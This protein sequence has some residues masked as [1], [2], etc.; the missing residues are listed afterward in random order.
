T[1]GPLHARMASFARIIG[2]SVLIASVVTFVSGIAL[3][4]SASAMFHTAVAMA[5]SAVPEGLPVAVT[6]TL[7]I[8]VSRM[9]RRNAVLRRLASME[10]LGSTTVVGSDKT[11]TLTENRMAVQAIWAGGRVVDATGDLCGPL[12]E[13]DALRWTLHTGV[14]TNEA[15]LVHTSD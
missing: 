11:G 8:G 10:T 6:V 12:A 7:A 15:D 5:V 14:M 13:S 1:E 9:A 3:G 2:T 4:E